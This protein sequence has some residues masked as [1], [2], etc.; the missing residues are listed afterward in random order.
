MTGVRCSAG[1]ILCLTSLCLTGLCLAGQVFAGEEDSTHLKCT[2]E[3]GI[4]WSYDAGKFSSKPSNKLEFEIGAINLDNQSATLLV[5]GKQSG[6]LKI[7]R[8]LNANHFLEVANEGFL[9]LT[10]VYDFDPAAGTYPAVH[11][12][13]FG[14]LG[15]PVFGQYAGT[16]VAK[17]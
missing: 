2:F 8:A 6:S 16:C 4:S 12:R 9:N 5:E 15:Q 7:V 10:T 14:L 1:L 11:S 3:T 17:Q 13:H